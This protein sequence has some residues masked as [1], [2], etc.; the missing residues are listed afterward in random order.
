MTADGRLETRFGY[1][2]K[3]LNAC[4]PSE[5]PRVRG[6]NVKAFRWEHRLQR[7]NLFMAFKRVPPM[8]V[9]S[10]QQYSNAGEKPTNGYT[11]HNLADA[12]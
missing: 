6:E 10:D 3:N 9:T 1:F 5:H 12:D 2:K 4:R 7:Q 11:V 8:V